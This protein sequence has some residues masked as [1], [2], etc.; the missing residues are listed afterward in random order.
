[1][2]SDSPT[3]GGQSSVVSGGGLSWKRVGADNRQ[4]GDAEVWAARATGALSSAK[5][6]AKQRIACW[7]E[8][9][10]VVALT[11]ATGIG[12]SKTADA[13]SGA[14]AGTLVTTQPES[15]VWAAGDDW[16][17]SVKRTPG[18]GQSVVHSATDKV[19]DTYWVQSTT[20]ATPAAGAAVTIDDTAPSTDPYNLVLVEVLGT[21]V[22]VPSVTAVVPGGGPVAGTNTVTVQGADLGGATE[23]DFGA[24]KATS[25]IAVAPDGSSLTVATPPGGAGAVDVRVTTAAGQSAVTAADQYTYTAAAPSAYSGAHL[26]LSPG[27]AGPNTPHTAQILKA[28]LTD[29][30][31]QP[32]AGMDVGFAVTGANQATNSAATDAQGVASF[33]YTGTS[34]GTDSASATFAAGPDTVTSQP[35]TITWAAPTT[36]V[37]AVSMDPSAGQFFAEPADAAAFTAK[38]GD[39]AAFAQTFPDLAFNP[40]PGVIAGDHYP[41][42]PT[43]HPLTDVTTDVAGDASGTLPAEGDGQQAGVGALASFDAVFT[44]TLHVSR[45]GDLSYAVDSADGFLLGIGNGASRVNGDYVNPPTSNQSAFDGYPLVA[46]SNQRSGGTVATHPVTIHFPAAGNYPLELDYFS[47]GGPQLSLVLR[48]SEAVPAAPN[49]PPVNVYVGYQDTLR[50]SNDYTIS[51]LPWY[52]SPNVVFEGDGSA[53]GPGADSG[54]VRFDNVTN[55]PV[56]LDK[57]TVDVPVPSGGAPVHYDEWPAGIVVN[58]GQTLI[59]AENAGFASFDTSDDD[60]GTC[61]VVQKLVPLINVTIGGATSTYRDTGEVLNTGGFDQACIGNES[62]PWVRVG[63]NGPAAPLLPPARTGAAGA[64]DPDTNAF[65]LYG[66]YNLAQ[67]GIYYGDTWVWQKGAWTPIA[68]A[69]APPARGWAGGAYDKATK[70]FVVFGG[71]NTLTGTS[72]DD[73]WTFDGHTWTQQH[74]V[75]SP[76]PSNLGSAKL[77]YD[78][79]NGTVVLV[80]SQSQGTQNPDTWTWDGTDWTEHPDPAQPSARWQPSLAYDPDLGEV[81]LFGGSTGYG[82]PDLSDTWAWDGT[83]WN[84][85]SPTAAPSART[86]AS[87]DYVPSAH[88]LVLFGGDQGSNETWLF[89]GTTWKQLTPAASPPGRAYATSAY[90]PVDSAE[91]VAFGAQNGSLSQP[92]GDLWF[93]ADETWSATPPSAAGPALAPATS[94]AI[95]PGRDQTYPAGLPKSFTVCAVDGTGQPLPGLAIQVRI[96]GANAATTT[97]TT[98]ANGVAMFLDPASATGADQMQATA[99]VDGTVVASNLVNVTW[100][101]SASGQPPT[102]GAIQP[103]DGSVVRAPTPVTASITAPAGQSIASWSVG[104]QSSAPGSPSTTLA[105]GSAAP[106]TPLATLDPT[107][108]ADGQY[109]LTL[110]ATASGGGAA[111]QTVALS[112]AGAMKLGAYQATYHELTVPVDGL[113]MTVDRVYNSTDHSAGDFGTGWRV[114][115]SNIQ[116]ATGRALGSGGWQQYVTDCG[117][118]SCDYAYRAVNVSHS[119]TVTW[120]DGHQEVFDFTPTGSEFGGLMFISPGYTP[121][122]GTGTVD[123]L[124]SSGSLVFGDDGNLYDSTVAQVSDGTVFNPTRF[125]LTTPDGTVYTLDTTTGLVRETNAAG[126]S[127]TVDGQGVHGSNGQ[128][129]TITRDPAGRITKIAGPDDGAAGENQHWTYTY[130]AAGQL[131]AVTDPVTTV[132]YDYDPSSGQLLGSSDANNQ[133]IST[134]TYGPD[135]R[136]ATVA[137]GGDPPIT[138]TANAATRTQ[139]VADPN[140]K[141]TTTE[142]FDADGNLAE[143][144]QASGGKT[145]KTTYTYDASGRP[146][147]TTGPTGAIVSTTYDESPGPTNGQILSDTDGDGRT[148]TYSAYTRFGRPGEELNPDGSVAQVVTYDPTTGRPLTDDVPGLAPTTYT[149]N[150][151]GTL[152]SAKD[153]AG[154]TT[155]Y[156]YDANGNLA[157]QTDAAGHTIRTTENSTG[158]AVAQTDASGHESDYA[159]DGNGNLTS[160]TAATTHATETATYNGFNKPLTV[161]DQDG[162]TTTYAYDGAGNVVKRTNPDGVVTTYAYDADGNLTAETSPTGTTH[163]TYDAFGQLA[164]TDNA[165]AEIDLAYDDAGRLL[166]Q[167]TC[168][169][170]PSQ[171]SCPSGSVTVTHAVDPA[172]LITAT[173]TPAGHTTY[174]YDGNGRLSAVTDPSGGTFVD[175]Y[176]SAGRLT[177]ALRPNGTLDSTTYNDADQATALTTTNRA[178]T[179]L[180]AATDTIDPATGQITAMADLDGTNTFTY[181]PDGTLATAAHP[182]ASALPNESYTYDAAGN[183]LT[184]PGGTS[185]YD[186]ANR[187]L[188][189]GANTYTWNGE[190]DVA[191]KTDTASHATTT[192][193]WDAD[194]RLVGTSLSTGGGTTEKYDPFGRLVSETSGAQTTTYLWDGETLVQQSTKTTSPV[195]TTVTNFVAD[196]ASGD[197]AQPPTTT[198][199]AITA[200]SATGTSTAYPMYNLHGDTTGTTTPQGTLSSPLTEFTAFGQPNVT[201]AANA[202]G[203]AAFDGYH[204]SATG[205]DASNARYYDPATGRFLSPDPK[206]ARNAYGYTANDPVNHWDPTGAEEL[207]EVAAEIEVNANCLGNAAEESPAASFYCLGTPNITSTQNPNAGLHLPGVG[208]VGIPLPIPPNPGFVATG[209][210]LQIANSVVQ[211]TIPYAQLR[212]DAQTSPLSG[213]VVGFVQFFFGYNDPSG[214]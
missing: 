91:L 51:P 209:F 198:L 158:L 148:I 210:V 197:P 64:W 49:T 55:A 138:V 122:P 199:E 116:V 187:L 167:T 166:K 117:I 80:T 26:V 95:S 208:N 173:G 14:P 69:A 98:D 109:N 92:L 105:S 113:A 132:H 10:T 27:V 147:S 24:A 196:P 30:G 65:V 186:A 190:G 189:D 206:P 96:T 104:L 8:A 107:S 4:L 136:V 164:E 106:P 82:G 205:Q 168:A 131:T 18:P 68:A 102:I 127:I 165:N 7:D 112:V 97:V 15:W 87:L 134:I 129:I 48:P 76:P 192:Y 143:R 151:D 170:A 137:Q 19:G 180:A 94:L 62:E 128:S 89:D 11:G 13:P 178:G 58:P 174:A 78:E 193:A 111:S 120:P 46:A 144:D 119:V 56:T 79:A 70:S 100:N 133:P 121:R 146:T 152:A 44:T 177:S 2:G 145:L 160:V 124:A 53:Q 139:T 39:T 66:G 101:A 67:S 212:A 188:S 71:Y 90:D 17:K 20:A 38:P 3:S 194:N 118:L 5:I 59:L 156:T 126:A 61:G 157:T 22:T 183:R 88:G 75:H 28:T 54:G 155:Q 114:D 84:Q 40:Q 153:P 142:L 34:A 25:G 35:S 1:M 50:A 85:L 43:T 52:G 200:T 182:A 93:L 211:S 135:G 12:A 171:T 9:L 141:L 16:L 184:G 162:K 81:V 110:T 32:L 185:T 45:P 169:S 149:Y 36:P 103:A 181:N 140:G 72:Y 41:A 161:T 47:R 204:P 202:A 115:L 172:G 108:L 31:G 201:S 125:T 86:G 195:S 191:T 60:A 163:Y 29:R 203:L 207:I 130:N 37:A 33:T 154:R 63:T 150:P 123:T 57:V 21:R 175:N 213:A 179:T 73:T 74:P 214:G 83:A 77:A 6:T 159:Y 99:A 176:D 42:S 23:V